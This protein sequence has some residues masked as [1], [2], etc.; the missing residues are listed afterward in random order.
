MALGHLFLQ[1]VDFVFSHV[2]ACTI[3]LSLSSGKRVI[4]F[5]DLAQA[6]MYQPKITSLDIT[7]IFYQSQP[8]G[9]VC[10]KVFS[11][12]CK[13][14]KHFAVSWSELDDDVLMY[15]LKK[16]PDLESLSLVCFLVQLGNLLL[17]HVFYTTKLQVV[18]L[19]ILF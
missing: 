15:L 1:S 8:L 19:Y 14:L 18:N 4:Q 16:E 7:N 9:V 6:Q 3:Y 5:G 10:L 2:I 17:L 12:A 11:K 13:C